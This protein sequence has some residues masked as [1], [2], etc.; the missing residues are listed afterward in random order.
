[1]TT[2]YEVLPKVKATIAELDALLKETTNVADFEHHM[3]YLQTALRST[4]HLA[5]TLEPEEIGALVAAIRAKAQEDLL[6]TKVKAPRKRAATTKVNV[7]Q[8]ASDD[9]FGDLFK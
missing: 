2:D 9:L 8:A 4:P 1:M 7:K 5:E 6:N 3:Q